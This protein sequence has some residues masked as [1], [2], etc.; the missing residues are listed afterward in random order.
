MAVSVLL[1]YFVIMLCCVF[2]LALFV[3][4]LCVLSFLVY[5]RLVSYMPNVV[6]VSGL[7]IRDCPFRSR[8]T[9]IL[10]DTGL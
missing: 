10:Q 8:L 7:S 4:V 3:F 1:I 6:S 5:I 9:F 2:C